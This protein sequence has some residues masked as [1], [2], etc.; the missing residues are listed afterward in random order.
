MACGLGEAALLGFALAFRV[1]VVLPT[2][3]VL[4]GWRSSSS[5]APSTWMFGT[6]SVFAGAVVC[7]CA[8]V[9]GLSGSVEVC[10]DAIAEDEILQRVAAAQT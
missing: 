8:G 7:A 4:R 2:G 5:L 10:W 6:V 3:V 9:V 1:A